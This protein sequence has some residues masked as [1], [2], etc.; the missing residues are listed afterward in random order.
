MRRATPMLVVLIC[1]ELSDVVFAVDSIPAVVGISQARSTYS[2][3][4]ALLTMAIL[5]MGLLTVRWW[6]SRRPASTM[7]SCR[8]H[9]LQ[10]QP[11][12]HMVTASCASQDPI[13]VCTL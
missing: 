9:H 8:L 3:T 5:S 7:H 1:I 12:P 2:S 11:P 10:L 6:A 4:M 13:V